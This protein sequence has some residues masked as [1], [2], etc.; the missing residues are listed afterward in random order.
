MASLD[1]SGP[2]VPGTVVQVEVSPEATAALTRVGDAAAQRRDNLVTDAVACLFDSLEGRLFESTLADG[3]LH[4]TLTARAARVLRTAAL[5]L[6]DARFS[7][8]DVATRLFELS[9]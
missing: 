2:S 6:E 7:G 4:L 5:V 3:R 8:D 9:L 1:R